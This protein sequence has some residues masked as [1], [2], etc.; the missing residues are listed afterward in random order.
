MG[1][2]RFDERGF[3][4]GDVDDSQLPPGVSPTN[5]KQSFSDAEF[6]APDTATPVNLTAE[7]KNAAAAPQSPFETA[8][9]MSAAA[10]ANPPK[11]SLPPGVLPIRRMIMLVTAAGLLTAVLAVAMSNRSDGA[12][13]CSEQPHWNQYNCQPG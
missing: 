11:A 13:L 9:D 8:R 2:R 4:L 12:A 7:Q 1:K 5:D 3:D 6:V 10:A